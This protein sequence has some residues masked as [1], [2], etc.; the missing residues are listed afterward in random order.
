[1]AVTLNGDEC[2]LRIGQLSGSTVYT[3]FR[4]DCMLHGTL[5]TPLPAT[6]HWK[7]NG[8]H[9]FTVKAMSNEARLVL[10]GG[11][12]NLARMRWLP[13]GPRIAIEASDREIGELGLPVILGLFTPLLI[14]HPVDSSVT[15]Y[16]PDYIF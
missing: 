12:R 14:T 10:Q 2:H 4:A 1:V 13:R 5:R 15:E 6:I 9:M 11:K 16:Q 7:S 3:L 8:K